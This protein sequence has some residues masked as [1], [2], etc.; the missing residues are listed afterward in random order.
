MSKRGAPV[1]A[2]PEFDIVGR[3]T[4]S[5]KLSALKWINREVCGVVHYRKTDTTVVGRRVFRLI[6]QTVNIL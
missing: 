1:V 3:S 5:L 4:I 2:A 6:C